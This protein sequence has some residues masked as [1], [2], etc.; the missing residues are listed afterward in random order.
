MSCPYQ[1]PAVL[2]REGLEIPTILA[3]LLSE[4]HLTRLPGTPLLVCL[5]QKQRCTVGFHTTFD[6]FHSFHLDGRVVPVRRRDEGNTDPVDT[7]GISDKYLECINM[8]VFFM[9]EGNVGG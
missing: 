1:D 2:G 6:G 4:V 8:V 3:P 5:G 7:F 9:A